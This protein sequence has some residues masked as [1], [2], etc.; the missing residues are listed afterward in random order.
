MFVFV[1]VR[2]CSQVVFLSIS[3]STFPR[4]GLQVE[5]SAMKVL[6]NRLFM[7][8]VFH[9]FGDQFLFFLEALGAAFQIF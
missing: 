4:L 5:V 3:E 1:F 6:Q 9:E 2:A 7:E 8:I